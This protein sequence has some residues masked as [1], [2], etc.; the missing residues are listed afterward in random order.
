MKRCTL[1]AA[2]M[3]VCRA[4][5]AP[6]PVTILESRT[7]VAPS[8]KEWTF[9]VPAFSVEH[10]VRLSLEARIDKNRLAGAG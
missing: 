9:T 8:V 5:A 3:V 7:S 1:L 4:W 6:G 10:Q 2:L